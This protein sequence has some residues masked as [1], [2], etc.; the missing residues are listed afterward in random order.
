MIRTIIR[1]L[2]LFSA[3][4]LIASAQVKWPNGLTVTFKDGTHVRVHTEST[5][6]K[7][8]LSTSGSVA[9]NEG[10]DMHRLVLDSNG[11]VLFG[12]TMEAWGVPNA[13]DL[14]F[15]R[16][17]P[18]DPAYEAR[19]RN[20][21]EARKKPQT[22]PDKIATVTAVRD[23]PTVRKGEAVSV[24]IL[25]NPST[26]ERIYD[27]LEPSF[28]PERPLQ[29]PAK[30][31]EDSFSFEN[32][33]IAIN[34]ETVQQATNTWVIGAAGMI[35]IPGHGAFYLALD[36]LPEYSFIASGRVSKEKLTFG[37]GNDWVEVVGKSNILSNSEYRTVWVYHTRDFQGTQPRDVMVAT[38]DSVSYLI[39]KPKK[40]LNKQE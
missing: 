37:E 24:D 27:V 12:Y 11:R 19:L 23:F 2:M 1:C 21:A 5:A 3:V 38:A 14:Y 15:V 18:L 29:T 31:Q 26:G 9:V 20:E 17:K 33:R 6:A 10:N 36:P 25:V 35:Y 32:P 4:S 40:T 34:G 28:A 16:L 22:I 30:V 7:S 13:Q 8:P 39:P